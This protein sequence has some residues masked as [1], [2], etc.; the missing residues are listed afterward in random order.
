MT[1]TTP[2]STE[3]LPG[4]AGTG[5]IPRPLLAG[6]AC[7]FAS[8]GMTLGTYWVFAP[9]FPAL[10]AGIAAAVPVRGHLEFARGALTSLVGVA[11][12]VAL[13]AVLMLLFH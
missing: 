13:F 4:D 9:I 1:D 2:P 12:F 8:V 3:S 11:V 5:R 10:V 7:G 6:F